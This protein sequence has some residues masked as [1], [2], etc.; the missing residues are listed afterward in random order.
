MATS[1][2]TTMSRCSGG[3]FASL[4]IFDFR[5][6]VF[7]TSGFCAAA[8]SRLLLAMSATYEPKS[9]DICIQYMYSCPV[10]TLWDPEKAKFNFRKHRIRFSDAESV[11]FDPTALTRADE[12]SDDEQRFVTIG[13]DALNRTLVVVYTYRGEDI[14]LISARRATSTERKAHEKRI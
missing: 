3:C 7:A 5:P 4:A 10:K 11:L 13:T 8:L 12:A 2:T 14:R 6:S 9:L 1:G